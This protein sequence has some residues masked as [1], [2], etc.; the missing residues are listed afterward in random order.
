MV[1]QTPPQRTEPLPTDKPDRSVKKTRPEGQTS[2]KL[3]E[4]GEPT[5][6]TERSYPSFILPR[7]LQSHLPD[8]QDIRFTADEWEEIYNVFP[9]AEDIIYDYP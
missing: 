7:N 2:S 6:P 9:T 4:E 8:P 3:S 1:E 5:Q